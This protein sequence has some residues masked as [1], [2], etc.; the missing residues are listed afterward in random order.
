MRQEGVAFVVRRCQC[1]LARWEVS[2]ERLLITLVREH[3][4]RNRLGRI[5][6]HSLPISQ[7]KSAHLSPNT[8]GLENQPNWLPLAQT[9]G[10][11][12]IATGSKLFFQCPPL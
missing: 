9:E 8:S 3:H 5:S 7:P 11:G 2:L 10:P 6:D 4:Y 1:D 12:Y